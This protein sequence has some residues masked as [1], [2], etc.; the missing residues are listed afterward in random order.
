MP[1]L[2]ARKAELIKYSH[3]RLE[4]GVNLYCCWIGMYSLHSGMYR[5]SCVVL[6]FVGMRL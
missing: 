4:G 3:I 2:V 6:F 5:Q 1:I